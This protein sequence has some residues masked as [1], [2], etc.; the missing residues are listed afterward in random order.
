MTGVPSGLPRIK[1]VAAVRVR[2]PLVIINKVLGV[3]VLIGAVSVGTSAGRGGAAARGAATAGR[4]APLYPRDYAVRV[5]TMGRVVRESIGQNA[6]PNGRGCIP[7]FPLSLLRYAT[8][9]PDPSPA[10]PVPVLVTEDTLLCRGCTRST[11]HD[12]IYLAY[13]LGH[14]VWV[15]TYR[16]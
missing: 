5:I 7:R 9:A 13:L 1:I 3:G 16:N 12:R 8:T 2:H 10:A 6:F 4:M 15:C 11:L 14:F